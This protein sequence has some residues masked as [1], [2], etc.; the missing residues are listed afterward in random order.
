MKKSKQ[1]ASRRS[2]IRNASLAAGSF[3]IVPRHVLGRG[4]VAPSDTL[5][6]AGIGAGGKGN[7]DLREFSK[8][9]KANIAFLCDVDDR[10][11]A[12][13]VK[14]FPKAKY[15]KDW[16]ELLDKEAK[17]IDAVSVSTPD[18]VHAVAAMAAMQ[19]GKHVYVQKPMT[20]DIYEA[21][22]LTQAARQYK[23]VT[24]MGNQGASGDGVR[25]MREWYNA[26]LIGDATQIHV[27]TN[28][29][30]WPQGL[31]NP[32][33]TDEIPKELNWDLWLGPAKFEAYHKEFL[34]FNWRGY[35]AYGTGALGDMGCHLI[36]PAFKVVGLGYPS[37]VECSEGAVFEKMWNAAYYPE[38]CPISSSVKLKFPGKDGK[39]DVKLYWMDG[40]IM[41]ERPDE[42][43]PDEKMGGSDGG[44]IITGTKG[45][46]M[47]DCYGANPTLLPTSKTKD[48]NVPQTLARVPEGHY[49][50]WVNACIAGFGKA[51]TSSNF[52]Y[53]GPLTETILMGN[54]ALRSYI[55]KSADGN[56]FPGRKKL[57][58]DAANMKITNYDEANQ[59][60]RRTYREGWKL[61]M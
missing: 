12:D 42:L 24:Q 29:P 26:G 61:G 52:D 55:T 10:Q 23:V 6:I 53:A 46:M 47:C 5:T 35:W 37:E 45:K 30:V 34:P 16:R 22:M 13:S 33:G 32:K 19:R 9:P 27:W 51:E 1:G 40:G 15:Y 60:V 58:W 20:H 50:Q 43:G 49:L 31:G 54:L 18:N 25:F 36:D 4:F 7:S 44:V 14:R 57:L 41:P 8:S 21:R 11:A 38:S 28:R 17:S 48:I 39:P 59:Y 2:F 56:S 3:F